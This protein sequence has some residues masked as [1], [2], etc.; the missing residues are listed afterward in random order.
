MNSVR[1]SARTRRVLFD[2]EPIEEVRR[3]LIYSLPTWT[4]DTWLIRF[5][6]RS[7]IVDVKDSDAFYQVVHEQAESD[8]LGMVHFKG[9][10]T[11][12]EVFIHLDCESIRP[13]AGSWSCANGISIQIVRRRVEGLLYSDFCRETLTVLGTS[14]ILQIDLGSAKLRDEG[15]AKNVDQTRGGW[16]ALGPRDLSLPG[17]YWLNFLGQPYCDLIG[18]DRLLSAPAFEV[19]EIG[20]GV[21]LA[22][23]AEPEEWNTPSYR[24]REQRVLD[25][26]GREYVFERDKP[27]KPTKGPFNLPSLPPHDPTKDISVLHGG[28]DNFRRLT[29]EE[30]AE[31]E[32][33]RRRSGKT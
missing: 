28:G 18:R 29:P 24:E 4:S 9:K 6:R 13:F 7:R 16:R 20:S 19:K 8:P 15:F 22:L 30:V 31:L 3:I 27:D 11:L 25:H 14:N 5:E 21:L 23:A 12:L 1:L 10:Y 2:R 32:P 26:I 17:L 33:K